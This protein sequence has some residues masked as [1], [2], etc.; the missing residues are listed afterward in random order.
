MFDTIT[1]IDEAKVDLEAG[2]VRGAARLLKQCTYATAEPALLERIH[3]LAVSGLA[4][5]TGWR[6][7]YWFATVD[8]SRLRYEHFSGI[9]APATFDDVEGEELAK[10]V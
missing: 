5:T 7:A 3:E 1:K 10:A 6:R 4:G 8:Q 2:R 9:S